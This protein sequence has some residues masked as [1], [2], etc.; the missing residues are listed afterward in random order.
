MRVTYLKDI[1]L[2]LDQSAYEDFLKNAGMEPRNEVR[3][4]GRNIYMR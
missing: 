2:I 3:S 1:P 4:N